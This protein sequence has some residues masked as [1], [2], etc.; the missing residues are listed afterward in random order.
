MK[1]KT[2]LG[3]SYL[4]FVAWLVPAAFTL[5]TPILFMR[6]LGLEGYGKYSLL[7]SIALFF[8]IADLSMDAF[9]IPRIAREKTRRDLV[10]LQSRRFFALAALLVFI[11]SSLFFYAARTLDFFKLGFLTHLQLLLI[12]MFT[13]SQLLVTS[14][15]VEASGSGNLNSYNVRT[16]FF[17][18]GNVLA[19]FLIHFAGFLTV[20]TLLLFKII[21][22]FLISGGSIIA[23]A[24]DRKISGY[25]PFIDAEAF[26]FMRVALLGKCISIAAFN[27]DKIII[28]TYL[29]V[30]DVG[31][32]S[33]PMQ[34]GLAIFMGASKL[35]VPLQPFAANEDAFARSGGM[36]STVKSLIDILVL[37]VGILVLLVALWVPNL[38]PLVYDGAVDES[39]VSFQFAAI[40][41]GFWLISLSAIAANILPS[42]NRMDL[43]VFSATVR[44]FILMVVMFL[45]IH[46]LGILAVGLALIAAG[47]WEMYFLVWFLLSNDLKA[48]CRRAL[49]CQGFIIALLIVLIPAKYLILKQDF[50]YSSA[51]SLMLLIV[52]IYSPLKAVLHSKE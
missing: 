31:I 11:L 52:L 8:T 25:K 20:E 4:N 42:W 40:L 43:N 21:T 15:Y 5:I 6:D 51:I 46:D 18:S 39:E 27:F 36:D 28:A 37:Y 24:I 38:V 48:S 29:T 13:A 44:S 3:S 45:A 26:A 41:V 17:N 14:S 47:I 19:I 33:Y 7:I 10:I 1:H 34:L 49:T 50:I 2:L 9:L 23:G 30:R 16:L 32:V 12:A 22:N 35:C